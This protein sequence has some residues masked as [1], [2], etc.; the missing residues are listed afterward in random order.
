MRYRW[1]AARV[2]VWEN[3]VMI[4][5]IVQVYVRRAEICVREYVETLAGR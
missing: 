1:L 3:E 5:N 4:T 2:G